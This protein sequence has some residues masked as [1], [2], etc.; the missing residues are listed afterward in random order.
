MELL[1]TFAGTA[2]RMTQWTAN[3]DHLINYDSNL[4]L[5]YVAGLGINRDEAG[6]IFNNILKYYSFPD[7]IFSGSP[8][9]MAAL[10]EVLAQTGRHDPE[11]TLRSF[12]PRRH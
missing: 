12:S 10:K 3:T 1:A 4:P 8:E 5:Q 7:E 11:L 6:M 2:P 9:R